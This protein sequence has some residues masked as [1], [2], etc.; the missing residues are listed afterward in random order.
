MA[1]RTLQ[2]A[3]LVASGFKKSGDRTIEIAIFLGAKQVFTACHKKVGLSLHANWCELTF[4][5]TPSG[6]P[7]SASA[8][9]NNIWNLSLDDSLKQSQAFLIFLDLLTHGKG[10]VTLLLSLIQPQAAASPASLESIKP[11]RVATS[12]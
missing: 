12:R 10:S 2:P 4:S 9:D 7:F 8:L 3:E 6:G 5:A 1:A 11:M